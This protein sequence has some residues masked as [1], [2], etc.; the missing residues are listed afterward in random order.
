MENATLFAVI[1]TRGP[2]WQPNLGLEQ[3]RDWQSHAAFM[4]KLRT[5]GFVVLGGPLDGTPDVLLIIRAATPEQIIARLAP[6]PWSGDLLLIS[7]ISPWTLRL[8]T[9]PA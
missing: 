9:L 8:G 1:R 5:D 7:K 2:A 6:D 4:N 3:Q